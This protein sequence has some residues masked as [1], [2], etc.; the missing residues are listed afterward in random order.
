M[1]GA[2]NRDLFARWWKQA[3]GQATPWWR[4]LTDDELDLVEGDAEKLVG[5]L[6]ARYGWTRE[7]A[8]QEIE[9]GMGRAA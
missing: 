1:E 7:Q 9:R 8:E 3:R 4:L 2:M 5:L 6:Q